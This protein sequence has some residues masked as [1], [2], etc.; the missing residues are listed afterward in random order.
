MLILYNKILVLRI[1]MRYSQ[2]GKATGF[3]PVTRWFESIYLNM[4]YNIKNIKLT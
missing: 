1:L 4:I 2:G 3:G